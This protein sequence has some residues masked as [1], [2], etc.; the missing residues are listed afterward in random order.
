[1]MGTYV[2]TGAF[3]YS[4]KSIARRLLDEG[5][6]VRT[7]TDSPRRAHGFGDRIAASPFHFD[8]PRALTASLEGAD[9]LINTYW[10][11][12]DHRDFT[13]ALAVEN[14]LALFSAARAAGIGRVVH[15]SITNPS[16][17]SPL[18]YFR[19]KAQLERALE[20]SGLPHSV[21]RPAVLFG[22]EDILI[23]NIAWAL[24]R[25]P[26]FGVF[27]DG[28]YGIQPIHVDDL[29]DL[30]V[31]E[32]KQV[33]R[34]VIDAI[35]PETFIFRGLVEEIG[36]AI[37]KPRRIV[38]VRP[39]L[40]YLATSILGRMLNDVLLTREEIEGLMRGLLCTHSRPT[41]E[42]RLSEWARSHADTLGVR[43]A[44]ELARRRNR[45]QA[46]EDL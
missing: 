44:A 30:A 18:P 14:T 8:D 2:V 9:V 21:L 7:L 12:F 24:R 16:L 36:S 15:I 39:S 19:G 40:A 22:R 31:S 3:G 4:G 11:R 17:D 33:G 35:G 28:E 23:N 5:H 26:V 13:H 37:G 42:T 29:A 1:M 38:S 46:Y 41:G 27:G 10:V 20:E 34:R 43:Y 32:S 6:T 25:F 45:L